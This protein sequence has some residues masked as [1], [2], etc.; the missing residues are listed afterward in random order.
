M[1]V[2]ILRYKI[3]EF[4]GMGHPSPTPLPRVDTRDCGAPSFGAFSF[5][6]NS[7][8]SPGFLQVQLATADRV[9]DAVYLGVKSLRKKTSQ[10][11]R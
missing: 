11:G 10:K 5:F 1:E 7:G 4:S 9:N 8:Y 6:L 3:K 2:D